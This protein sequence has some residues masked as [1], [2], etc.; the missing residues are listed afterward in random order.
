MSLPSPALCPV[1]FK[2]Q[3]ERLRLALEL[4]LALNASEQHRLDLPQGGLCC[5]G[6]YA[7]EACLFRGL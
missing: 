1:S 6:L 7:I 5:P 4:V 2:Y 3:Q